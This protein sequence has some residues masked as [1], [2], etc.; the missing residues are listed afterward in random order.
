METFLQQC[1]ELLAKVTPIAAQAP[2]TLASLAPALAVLISGAISAFVVYRTNRNVIDA[3]KSELLNE[4]LQDIASQIISSKNTWPQ[5]EEIS[6]NADA[7]RLLVDNN[8][9]FGRSLSATLS[10]TTWNNANEFR[11]WRDGLIRNVN[12]YLRSDVN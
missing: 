2:L 12:E 4:K 9:K 3:K 5:T 7:A 1:G 6:R 10:E 8:N 11:D